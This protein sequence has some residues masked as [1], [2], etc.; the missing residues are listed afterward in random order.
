MLVEIKMSDK[1]IYEHKKKKKKDI[2][3]LNTSCQSKIKFLFKKKTNKQLI[4]YSKK[5]TK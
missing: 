1:L 5:Q 4:K 2:R 3:I